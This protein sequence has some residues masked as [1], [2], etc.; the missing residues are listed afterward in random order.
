MGGLMSKLTAFHNNPVSVG[1][2]S[3]HKQD[4]IIKAGHGE[5]SPATS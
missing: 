2:G 1:I 3:L 5:F 4:A